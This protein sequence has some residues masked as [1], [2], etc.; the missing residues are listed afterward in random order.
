MIKSPIELLTNQSMT[1]EKPG[2]GGGQEIERYPGET[3]NFLG[4]PLQRK[5][6]NLISENVRPLNELNAINPNQIFGTYKEANALGAMREQ[7]NRTPFEEMMRLTSIHFTPIDYQHSAVNAHYAF[8][9]ALQQLNIGEKRAQKMG[10]LN[11][12]QNLEDMKAKLFNE[13]IPE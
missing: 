4:L 2:G 10:K 12:I 6:A 9:R 5:Y 3:T 11:D 8:E 1:F 7:T 13:A